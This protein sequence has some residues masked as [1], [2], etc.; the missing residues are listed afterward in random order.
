MI[1]FYL[2]GIKTE[3]HY[4]F[5]LLI[6]LVI[7]TGNCLIAFSSAF[8]SLLHELAHGAVARAFGYHPQK[9]SAGLFGGVLYLSETAIK[10]LHELWI[11]LAGPA[12][13][14]LVAALLYAF[15]FFYW[16]N[17]VCELI[18]C[19]IILGI[20][21]L[22]PF[23]PL[24]GGKIIGLYLAYFFGYGKAERFSEIFSRIFSV[25]LFLFGLY[26]VQYNLMNLL[27]CALAVN[28]A[29]V[30]RADNRFLFYKLTKRI[31]DRRQN[32]KPKMVVCNQH[33][34]AIKILQA[35][36][37]YEARLF[38]IVNRKGS[39]KGQLSEEEVLSGIYD[40]G[41]Y[42]DFHKLL[43]WKRKKKQKNGE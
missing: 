25:L 32:Y 15:S 7:L 21:N 23:Y 27:I 42:V 8:F 30:T 29:M 39:Y 9:I 4:S 10:P 22:M 11:H 12:F 18:L 2:R 40:C 24:D 41:I 16:K 6:I 38:T 1:Q 36:R 31:E 35:Y 20:F 13:N 14:I 37:P 34:Q 17:W 26:L 43:I 28:L 3:V 19:N 33:I 5:F